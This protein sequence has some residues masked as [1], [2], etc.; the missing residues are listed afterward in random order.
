MKTFFAAII[1]FTLISCK[2]NTPVQEC[3]PQSG[4]FINGHHYISGS[5]LTEDHTWN[6]LALQKY[7]D[8]KESLYPDTSCIPIEPDPTFEETLRLKTEEM[9]YRGNKN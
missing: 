3:N 7:H 6:Y 9:D 8:L 1:V 5:M 2:G 4:R